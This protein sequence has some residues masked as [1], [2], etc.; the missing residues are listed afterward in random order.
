MVHVPSCLWAIPTENDN[1]CHKIVMVGRKK[2]QG[3]K[4]INIC[5]FLGS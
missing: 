4:A 2:F 1:R 5:M 3:N